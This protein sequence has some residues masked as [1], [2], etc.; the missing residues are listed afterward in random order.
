MDDRS[1]ARS[2]AVTCELS[3]AVTFGSPSWPFSPH[4]GWLEG[5]GWGENWKLLEMGLSTYTYGDNRYYLI[6]E[7]ASLGDVL[8]G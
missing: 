7:A 5:V 1:G 6:S 3:E 2:E 8:D 4:R